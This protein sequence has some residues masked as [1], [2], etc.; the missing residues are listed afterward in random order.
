MLTEKNLHLF[1][2]HLVV[3]YYLSVFSSSCL[4]YVLA[5]LLPVLLALYLILIVM[6]DLISLGV[7][8]LVVFQNFINELDGGVQG[9]LVKFAADTTLGRIANIL[10]QCSHKS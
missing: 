5:Q 6:S 4:W 2:S 9:M 3:D 10:E 8:G 7:L 1:S